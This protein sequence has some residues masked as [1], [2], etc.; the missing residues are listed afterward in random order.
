MPVP[1]LLK[2]LFWLMAHVHPYYVSVTEIEY[3]SRTGTVG[4]SCKIFTDDL[5]EALKNR[6]VAGVDLVKGDSARNARW[7][8][9]YLR[10]HLSMSA[11]GRTVE[12]RFIGFE[13]DPEATWCYFEKTGVP[14]FRNI[15]VTSDLLYETR[16]EQINILHVTV[17]GE[18]RSKRLVNPDKVFEASF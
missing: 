6:G 7:I 5:E 16:K 17:D 8:E 11:D 14:G 3:A 12:L 15:R 4:L 10:G 9:S 18:R 1:L 2:G 13:N